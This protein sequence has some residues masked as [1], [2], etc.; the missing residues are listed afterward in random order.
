MI[1]AKDIFTAI[2]DKVADFREALAAVVGRTFNK[3]NKTENKQMKNQQAHYIYYLR[4]RDES[5]PERKGEPFGCVCFSPMPC[6][7]VV[8]GVSIC[9][10]KDQFNRTRGRHLAI[11]R[12]NKPHDEAKHVEF[13]E[14][15][16]RGT[17]MLFDKG[18]IIGPPT[19]FEKKI[20]DIR[21]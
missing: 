1:P 3:T 12:H 8:R 20:L 9:S 14:K 21:A 6:G 17:N 7:N 5:N 4:K 15:L 10:P 16:W 13:S 2:M 18:V 19:E 11:S